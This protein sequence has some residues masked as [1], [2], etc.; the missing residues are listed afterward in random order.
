M[1]RLCLAARNLHRAFST[2]LENPLNYNL[3]YNFSDNFIAKHQKQLFRWNTSLLEAQDRRV[4]HGR[5]HRVNI[6]RC[7]SKLKATLD[8]QRRNVVPIGSSVNGLYGKSSDLDLVVIT[9]NNDAQ[10]NDFCKKF[11]HSEHFR[12]HQMGII[13]A[14][15]RK[16]NLIEVTSVQQILFSVVPILKF[17]TRDGITVDVQFNN[18]GPIR[19]SL[20]VKACVQFNI[21]VPVV[22]HW[23][24]SFFAAVKLKNSRH[25]LFSTYHLNMLALHFLQSPAISVLP[26]MVASCPILHPSTPWQEVAYVLTA[27]DAKVQIIETDK[28]P[29]VVSPAE[30]IIKMI[31]YYSQLDLH[32]VSIDT[33]G[34][35]YRRLP[36]TTE[37]SYVQ[38]IDPYFDE[39]TSSKLRCNV[40][41]GPSLVQQAFIALRS[42]LKAGNVPRIFRIGKT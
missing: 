9:D 25:G 40:R 28:I 20:F 14:A 8:N 23:L 4:Q 38:L 1:R 36:E 42:E 37:D 17:K 15:L 24:N 11:N 26:D 41:N 7:L 30:V 21:V 31:D 13:T 5:K 10:R 12:R 22:V 32:I 6:D 27:K 29:C 16:A 39:D 19:S 33:G 18:I 2:A 3:N 34:R 35:I